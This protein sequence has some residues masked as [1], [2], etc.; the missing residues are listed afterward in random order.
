MLPAI[1]CVSY[2]LARLYLTYL[3]AIPPTRNWLNVTSQFIMA[4]MMPLMLWQGSWLFL[5]IIAIDA[6]TLATGVK[7]VI[8]YMDPMSQI[9]RENVLVLIITFSMIEWCLVRWF[10]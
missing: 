8:T 4:L 3:S 1:I 6:M 2:M 7:R 10:T 9:T 5:I